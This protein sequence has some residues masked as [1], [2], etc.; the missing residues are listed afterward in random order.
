MW[1]NLGADFV[2]YK[3]VIESDESCKEVIDSY[4]KSNIPKVKVQ[5]KNPQIMGSDK[6]DA[7]IGSQVQKLN[8]KVLI[9]DLAKSDSYAIDLV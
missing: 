1:R 4:I 5:P 9:D 3:E 6:Q 8:V 2:N 7:K